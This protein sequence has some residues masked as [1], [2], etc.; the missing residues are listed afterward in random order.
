MVKYQPKGGMCSNCINA[1]S[2][3]SH[4]AFKNMPPLKEHKDG[5]ITVRCTSYK[6]DTK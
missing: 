6:Q 3:C 1:K 4:L 2:D 5:T